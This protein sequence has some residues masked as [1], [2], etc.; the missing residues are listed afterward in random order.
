MENGSV[1][2]TLPTDS[3]AVVARYTTSSPTAGDAT[4]FS[5]HPKFAHWNGTEFFYDL[6]IIGDDS[7]LVANSGAANTEGER[8]IA[9]Q[10]LTDVFRNWRETTLMP[11]DGVVT[12]TNTG[13]VETASI[14]QTTGD[15]RIVSVDAIPKILTSDIAEATIPVTITATTT[16]DIGL[17][18]DY[19]SISQQLASRQPLTLYKR[20]ST[21]GAEHRVF[22]RFVQL[23]EANQAI[24]CTIDSREG[25]FT[26]DQTGPWSLFPSW[27][28]TGTGGSGTVSLT[29]LATVETIE[30]TSA[31]LTNIAWA[32][33]T[34]LRFTDANGRARDFSG[35][36]VNVSNAPTTLGHYVEAFRTNNS[37]QYFV[38]YTL[39][40]PATTVTLELYGQD[41]DLNGGNEVAAGTHTELFLASDLT[42]SNLETLADTTPVY[43][44]GS[45]NLRLNVSYTDGTSEFIQLNYSV[46][47]GVIG[48][49]FATQENL[50]DF[51]SDKEEFRTNIGIV[52]AELRAET[53]LPL[54]TSENGNPTLSS[55]TTYNLQGFRYHT[56][57][58]NRSFELDINGRAIQ[59]YSI[60]NGAF[61]ETFTLTADDIDFIE[62]STDLDVRLTPTA[63]GS[64]LRSII[65]TRIGSGADFFAGR[66]RANASSFSLNLASIDV[67]TRGTL[68]L[69]A[70][71]YNAITSIGSISGLTLDVFTTENTVLYQFKMKVVG[72]NSTANTI[73]G[74][75]TYINQALANTTLTDNPTSWIVTFGGFAQETVTQPEPPSELQADLPTTAIEVIP[76]Q[77]YKGRYTLHTPEPSA[78]TVNLYGRPPVTVPATLPSTVGTH[79]FLMWWTAEDIRMI[80]D[81]N[82]DDAAVYGTSGSN[83]SLITDEGSFRFTD[84]YANEREDIE[85]L[86]QRVG[87]LETEF[88]QVIHDVHADAFDFVTYPWAFWNT[89]TT[90]TVEITY[91]DF[92]TLSIFRGNRRPQFGGSA[93]NIDSLI[94]GEAG[95]LSDTTSQYAV[96]SFNRWDG[97]TEEAGVAIGFVLDGTNPQTDQ[98]QLYYTPG[99]SDSI[100]S[101]R[102]ARVTFYATEALFLAFREGVTSRGSQ[103]LIPGTRAQI[104][105]LIAHFGTNTEQ[106]A[107]VQVRY[108]LDG[109]AT[110]QAGEVMA[111]NSN[112]GIP[113]TNASYRN[114][115]YVYLQLVGVT[116]TITPEPNQPIDI[117]I[118]RNG[119]VGQRLTNVVQNDDGT[120][121]VTRI[122]QDGT[123]TTIV[124]ANEII[125]RSDH[126]AWNSAGAP[127]DSL[128]VRGQV[129]I[130]NTTNI[131]Q[132]HYKTSTSDNW[133][134]QNI[135]SSAPSPSAEL[136]INENGGTVSIQPST[137]GN[138]VRLHNNA[139]G[140]V[141]LEDVTTINGIVYVNKIDLLLGTRGDVMTTSVNIGGTPTDVEYR[142]YT[143]NGNVI[144][145]FRTLR[146]SGTG[147]SRTYSLPTSQRGMFASDLDLTNANTITFN[148]IG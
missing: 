78:P 128:G 4:S 145:Y 79:E 132:I 40:K 106:H 53:D 139:T 87:T 134:S 58:N 86:Q 3:S 64:S 62:G 120:F 91:D 116:S 46:G 20:N 21:S 60:E 141:I 24:T 55:T 131:S 45:S 38:E 95:A 50:Q 77:R 146:V 39:T 98:W 54:V 88:Q 109:N 5:G 93:S 76:L 26:S 48:V 103:L 101:W 99:F 123:S 81:N 115:H 94:Q 83:L 7:Y 47:N 130:D 44:D 135:I 125:L 51:I 67:G 9:G 36:S 75:I 140:D 32:S 105:D 13:G 133:A 127:P 28:G 82:G 15:D 89:S 66:I 11:L 70:E 34:T 65:V 19:A 97:T 108:F 80:T 1:V 148:L 56:T 68:T 22:V 16:V 14:T 143:T 52:D 31:R 61:E 90:S 35:V 102:R 69:T 12:V 111:V 18:A 6:E 37:V 114:L 104:D 41:H 142:T 137:P 30:D 25:T 27:A 74:D 43:G 100:P 107:N 59:T 33:D 23:D 57:G 117:F 122:N 121:S 129:A 112:G 85:A 126:A 84:N 49:Q 147:G 138:N 71:N 2:A 63:V 136:N 29:D 124:L 17:G 118:D 110:V 119:I 73:M 72:F 10:D 96:V 92:Q 42:I 144:F 8:S 113:F